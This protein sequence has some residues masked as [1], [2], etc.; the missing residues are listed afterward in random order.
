MKIIAAC[1]S[2]KGSLSSRQAN[3][4][5]RRGILEVYP[6]CDVDCIALGDGG[7]GTSEAIAWSNPGGR[8]RKVATVDP[9]RRP[10][11]A[12]YYILPKGDIAV[13]ECAAAAGITL[14]SDEELN[15]LTATTFGLGLM[16]ADAM[17]HGCRKIAVGL[18]GSATNDGGTGMLQAL[19]YRFIDKSGREIEHVDGSTLAEIAVID[20]SRRLPALDSAEITILCDV[21]NPLTGPNGATMI[22]G[23]Q[24]GADAGMLT[25]LE[26]G[27]L[28]YAGIIGSEAA[29]TPGAGAAG[30]LGAAFMTFLGAKARRGIDAVLELCRFDL[31]I[32][33]ADLVISGEGRI[34]QSSAMG[35]APGGVEAH[36]AAAGVRTLIIGGHVAANVFDD[37]LQVTPSD[38]PLS[39]AMQPSVAMRNIRTS[40]AAYLA[41]KR[42][43]S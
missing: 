43:R 37:V 24:K 6:N 4:A 40:I 42:R 13:I 14:L 20:G 25:T 11:E 15:P 28:N 35:K 1:D 10:I 23:P 8:W 2:F 30:G 17:D 29:N 5:C 3:E 16:I 33:G 18:G 41:D 26:T 38:M 9:L 21:T 34:D 12:A 36:A 32:A 19:G 7:E 31:R 27:M 22:Y 39:L